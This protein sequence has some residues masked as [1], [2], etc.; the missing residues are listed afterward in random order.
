M[1]TV[2]FRTNR[3][4]LELGQYLNTGATS[5]RFVDPETGEPQ[6]TATTNLPESAGLPPYHFFLKDWSE[7]AGVPQAMSKLCH[8]VGVPVQSGFVKVSLYEAG[9]ELAK[10]IDDAPREALDTGVPPSSEGLDVP[11]LVAGLNASGLDVTVID[12]DESGEPEVL[13]YPAGAQDPSDF[14][15]PPVSDDR[16][17][18]AEVLDEAPPEVATL[19]E[20]SAEAEHDNPES[21]DPEPEKRP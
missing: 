8:R 9:D 6:L 10:L 20:T 16:D 15:D 3:F 21:S 19:R 17:A 11:E 18:L 4:A 13:T 12:L 5:I 14:A 2:N 1:L 7:N